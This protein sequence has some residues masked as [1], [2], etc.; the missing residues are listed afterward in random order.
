MLELENVLKA[1]NYPGF[2]GS[3]LPTGSPQGKTFTSPFK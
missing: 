3:A 2:S 1:N